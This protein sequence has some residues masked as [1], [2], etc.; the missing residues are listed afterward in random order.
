VTL[1]FPIVELVDRLAIAEVKFQRTRANEQELLWYKDQ[2]LHVDLSEVVNEYEDLKRIHNEIWNL[3]AE[4]KSGREA[5]LALEE[6]GRRAIAIR[7]HNNKRVALKNAIA[8]KLEC[9][10][11]EI[12]KDHLS[13]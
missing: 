6:I 3:E 13:Q 8:E 7:N 1:K 2:A 11:R 12:K 10:V 5:E 9:P 4:L